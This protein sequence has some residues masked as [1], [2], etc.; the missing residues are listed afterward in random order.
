MKKLLHVLLALGLL[1]SL[2]ITQEG[3]V[4]AEGNKQVLRIGVDVIP[5]LLDPALTVNDTESSVIKGLFEG[6]VRL[7][8]NG[9][10]VPGIAKSW[11]ISGGGKTYTFAL[12][13][14]AKWSNGQPLKAADFEYAW[15][16]ALSP[17]SYNSMA[18][19]MYMIAGAEDYHNGK[20]KDA[21]KVGIKALND[22]TLQVTLAAPNYTFLQ[23]LAE[24]IYLPLN[25]AAVKA[26]TGWATS[27]KAM[28]TNGP[29]RL[30]AWDANKIVLVKNSGYY[31]AK[32][33]QFSEV[34]FLRPAA[35]QPSN[36]ESYLNGRL[37]WIGSGENTR[38]D[39]YDR[40]TA[41]KYTFPYASLY[42]YQFNV[43]E[44]PF[45][46]VKIR[47]A[48]AMAVVREGL[49]YGTPAYGDIAPTIHGAKQ[50]FRS[51]IKDSRYFREDVKAA[52]K[53]L[54]EGLKE[55]GLTSLPE[56][57]IIVNAEQSHDLIA[58]I[59]V[60]GWKE[61]LGIKANIEVQAWNE[62]LDNRHSQNYT[63]A[64]AGWRADYNDPAAFLEYFTSWSADNDSGWSNKQYDSYILQA[65]QKQDLAERMRLYA[66]AEKMLIDEMVILPLYY[67]VAD[68]L[69]KPNVHNVYVDFD[70]S[71]AF[72]RGYLK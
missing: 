35:G 64:R 63:V 5:G 48:L 71:I 11:E 50:T 60:S 9:Q 8:E 19:K 2:G 65:R 29:F 6:L 43:N 40:I 15:K 47:K 42:Y 70:G 24:N 52:Q 62:L 56:F 25:A 23:M 7:N 30:A 13:T 36:T 67:Y 34:Q 12:R 3:K 31:G 55:E 17:Q 68:V 20:Q 10:A 51:E 21:S 45:N 14:S 33:I 72:T 61:N 18:F 37:D 44:A 32:Q 58:S 41:E 53:L 22:H 66:K 59:I 39:Y 57:N 16:R 69:K 1:F 26:N 46:N 49:P 54:Q 27:A 38:I 4:S 28:V